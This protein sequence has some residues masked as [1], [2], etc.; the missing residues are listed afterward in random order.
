M[1]AD[2]NI[3]HVQFVKAGFFPSKFWR[4][5]AGFHISSLFTLIDSLCNLW[6]SS[7]IP[8]RPHDECNPCVLMWCASS[9]RTS[10]QI[11][12]RRDGVEGYLFVFRDHTYL[13]LREVLTPYLKLLKRPTLCRIWIYH[14]PRLPQ[15]C[16]ILWDRAG[17][18]MVL[19]DLL[20]ASRYEMAQN[21]WASLVPSILRSLSY[22]PFNEEFQVWMHPTTCQT[23]CQNSSKTS[24]IQM[25]ICHA[26]KDL[27]QICSLPQWFSRSV[28]SY[29]EGMC[30]SS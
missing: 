4:N 13:R 9:S 19:D 27:S 21:R 15:Y 5:C 1:T 11:F 29:L 7:P 6:I 8:V 18:S 14:F 17:T 26:N 24:I 10:L 23:P 16:G 22:D 3:N 2:S 28:Q 30:F 12:K 25:Y 20:N